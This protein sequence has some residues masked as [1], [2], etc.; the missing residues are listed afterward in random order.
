MVARTATD[1]PISTP[2]GGA[3]GSEQKVTT[4]VLPHV[5]LLVTGITDLPQET[6][7]GWRH[8]VPVTI[9]ALASDEAQRAHTAL[10]GHIAM[11]GTMRE[12]RRVP[13]DHDH[14]QLLSEPDD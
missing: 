10:Q 8:D 1:I 6:E 3:S 14:P 7:A 9:S 11:L 12:W 2:T 4:F 5:Q 13:P